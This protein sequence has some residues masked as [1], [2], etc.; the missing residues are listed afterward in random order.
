MTTT[1]VS[2]AAANAIT[3][4]ETMVALSATIT[5][6][7][8][9]G[10]ENEKTAYSFMAQSV[11]SYRDCGLSLIQL[12]DEFKKVGFTKTKFDEYVDETFGIKVRMSQ[13][14]VQLAKHKRTK[15]VDVKFFSKMNKPTLTNVITALSFSDDD[16]NKVINGDDTPFEPK[17]LTEAEKL[18]ELKKEFESKTFTNITFEQYKTYADDS[19]ANLIAVIDDLISQSQKGLYPISNADEIAE[20]DKVSA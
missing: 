12:K 4:N 17:T 16:W 20:S 11:I 9:K 10:K 19:K 14:Y 2:A 15:D 5:E 7:F 6:T 13:R 8:A 18:A 3:L 1:N